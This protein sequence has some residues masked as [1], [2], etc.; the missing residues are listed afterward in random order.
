MVKFVS[1]LIYKYIH[2]AHTYFV[3]T[4]CHELTQGQGVINAH[5]D[6]FWLGQT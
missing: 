2:K 1:A 4:K 5:R 6:R 3:P